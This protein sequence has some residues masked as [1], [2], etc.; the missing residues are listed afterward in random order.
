M[1]KNEKKLRH[2]LLL[3]I[4]KRQNHQDDEE[5]ARKQKNSHSFSA[6]KTRKGTPDFGP[7]KDEHKF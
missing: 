6:A 1:T 5:D 7:K 4:T 2:L 3:I